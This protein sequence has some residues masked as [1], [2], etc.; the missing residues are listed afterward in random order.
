MQQQQQCQQLAPMPL[1]ATLT[2]LSACLQVKVGLEEVAS[3]LY[4]VKPYV[5]SAPDHAAVVVFSGACVLACA[6]RARAHE[7]QRMRRACAL[8][9]LTSHHTAARAC[10]RLP[11]QPV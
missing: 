8:S 5:Y 4:R 9:T 11:A 2:V 7:Q 10:R 3:E 1:L 6:T